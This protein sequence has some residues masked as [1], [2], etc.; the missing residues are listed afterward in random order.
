MV[1]ALSMAGVEASAAVIVQVGDI[2]D[3]PPELLQIRYR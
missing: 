1:R 3:N 2:N